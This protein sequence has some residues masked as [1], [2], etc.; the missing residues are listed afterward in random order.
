MI[1]KRSSIT[2]ENRCAIFEGMHQWRYRIIARVF[3]KYKVKHMKNEFYCQCR[4]SLGNRHTHGYIPS[5][6]AKV[7]NEVELVDLGGFWRIDEVGEKVSADFVKDNERNYKE[8][9]G[10]TKGGGID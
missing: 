5:W 10:S 7:G 1:S 8:F 4:F 2:K 3:E 6:A 9:Q